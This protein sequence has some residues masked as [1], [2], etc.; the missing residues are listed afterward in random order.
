MAEPGKPVSTPSPPDMWEP[1]MTK[2]RTALGEQ[3]TGELGLKLEFP[4]FMKANFV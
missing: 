4:S 3:E 1:V 2:A